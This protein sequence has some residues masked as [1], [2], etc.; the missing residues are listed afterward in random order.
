MRLS[1][2]NG[3]HADF[4]MDEG[5][6]SLGHAA[7]NTFVLNARDVTAHHARVVVDARGA[8]LEVL[9]P[10]A[11][12]HVNARPV[13]EK[14]LLRSGDVLCVGQATI[15]LKADRDELVVTTVPPPS[16]T[17][18]VVASPLARV[19]LRGVSGGYYGKTIPVNRQ[20]R[21]GSR[22]DSDLVLD[23]PGIAA[24]H[25]TIE[26]AGRAIHL[27]CAAG[28]EVWV[29]GVRVRSAVLHSGDQLAFERSHFVVEAAGL[30]SRPLWIEEHEPAAAESMPERDAGD[31]SPGSQGGI[32]WLIGV[33]TL[34]A[35]AIAWVLWRGSGS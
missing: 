12:T 6:V 21:I 11:R 22:R 33:A 24:S 15:V 16:T 27:R 28:A 2:G 30:P 17:E 19:V 10:Q 25:A 8:I 34:I 20:L 14:A 5:T 29:N 26:H 7:D 31:A 3:E 4:V 13:R 18:P 23:E 1:F 9:D 35:A 32:W